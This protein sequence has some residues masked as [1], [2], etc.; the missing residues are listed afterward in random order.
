M[1]FHWG[2]G[3]GH[4]YSHETKAPSS[5]AGPDAVAHQSRRD[6]SDAALPNVDSESSD[7]DSHQPANPPLNHS[8]TQLSSDDYAD[9]FREA[10]EILADASNESWELPLFLDRDEDFEGE[11]WEDDPRFST[12]VG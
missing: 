12:V 6:L 8:G 2:L 1:R 7:E 10:E 3:V 11:E 9:I 4:I 5:T